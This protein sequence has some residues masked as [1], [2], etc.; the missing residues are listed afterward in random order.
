MPSTTPADRREDAA[1]AAYSRWAREPDRAAALAPARAGMRA[2]IDAVIPPEV[3][4]PA[5]RARMINSEINRRLLAARLRKRAER[6]AATELADAEARLAAVIED[7]GSD[8][9]A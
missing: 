5:V 2:L 4:D 3:T 6:Q 1:H 9:V 7:G 8:V